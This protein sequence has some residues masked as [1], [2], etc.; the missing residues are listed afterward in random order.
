MAQEFPDR[1]QAYHSGAQFL[2]RCAELVETNQSSINSVV[3]DSKRAG[4]SSA[5]AAATD[6][7]AASAIDGTAERMPDAGAYRQRARELIAKASLATNPT[8]EALDRFAWFL[9]TCKDTSFRD[10]RRALELAKKGVQLVPERFANRLTLALA[11]YRADDLQHAKEALEKHMQLY[12]AGRA[13]G[14]PYCAF[15]A[16]LIEAKL[17]HTNKAREC[18]ALAAYCCGPGETSDPNLIDIARE[19]KGVI[20]SLNEN[21]VA[22]EPSTIEPL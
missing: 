9:L 14:D 1:L 22:D 15:V 13:A 10:T 21:T 17:G 18:Y 8:P 7:L 5:P 6:G 20:E 2:L 12:P 19:A 16:T 3:S 11:Y 4:L